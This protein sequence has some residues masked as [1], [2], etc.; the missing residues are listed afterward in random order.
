[1]SRL[2]AFILALFLTLPVSGQVAS[3]YY[4]GTEPAD[5][6]NLGDVTYCETGDCMI[7]MWT[8][9]DSFDSWFRFL[10]VNSTTHPSTRFQFYQNG[11]G[12]DKYVFDSNGAGPGLVSSSAAVVDTWA[13]VVIGRDYGTELY[14]CINGSCETPVAESLGDMGNSYNHTLGGFGGSDSYEMDGMI[15]YFHAWSRVL[16]ASEHEYSRY[17]PGPI[18]GGVD[19]YLSLTDS[20]TQYDLSGNGNNGTNSGTAAH[21]DGPPVAVNCVAGGQF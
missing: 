14:L 19:A 4:D 11:A 13:W 7:A 5:T 6:V 12:A 1:V 10:W 15:A 21:S 8:Y 16:S 2:T 18:G 3:R 20:S 9:I 17:C